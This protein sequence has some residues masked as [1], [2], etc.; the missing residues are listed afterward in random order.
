MRY[1]KTNVFGFCTQCMFRHPYPIGYKASKLAFDETYTMTI[2]KGENGPIFTVSTSGKIFR[3]ATPTAPW[4][5][6][7][8]RSKSQGTR[9]SGPLFYGFSDAITMKL[10]E[11]MEG[12]A[13]A[14][15]PEPE[16]DEEASNDTKTT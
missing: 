9:V 16:E 14:S 3:G 6:A 10:L 12:Y 11:E 2:S 15:R 1:G 8:K 7:C 13:E 4:T 5:E